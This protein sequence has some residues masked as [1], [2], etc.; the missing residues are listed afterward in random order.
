VKVISTD[1]K[2]ALQLSKEQEEWIKKRDEKLQIDCGLVRIREA[3]NGGGSNQ[4][5]ELHGE[6]LRDVLEQFSMEQLLT[7][8]AI[9]GPDAPQMRSYT[10]GPYFYFG[11]F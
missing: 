4:V 11:K 2:K 8:E 1:I 6:A 5:V 3:A 7:W 10:G 9:L